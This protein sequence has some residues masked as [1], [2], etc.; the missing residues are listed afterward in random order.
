MKTL[1]GRS[2]SASGAGRGR[3]RSPRR[4]HR[5]GGVPARDGAPLVAHLGLRRPREPGAEAGR[6]HHR[7]HRRKARDH[8]APH[9]RQGPRA[10]EPL[11]AQGHEGRLRLRRQ[12][13]QDLPL[14]VPRLDLPYGRF[15][16]PHPAEGGL[17]KD[18]TARNRG[19][20][21][22]DAGHPRNLPRLRLRPP[23]RRPGVPRVLRRLALLHRQPRRPLARGRTGD[24]GRLPALSPQLQLEDVRGEPE[25][26][27]APDDRA[28][29]FRRHREAA[30]G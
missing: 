3:P 21:R 5:P 1:P 19:R 4:L 11:R 29:L 12:Y 2:A 28:R 7:R 24:R 15:P 13:R 25:R 23:R 16:P 6:L 9:R 20:G 18:Q 17:R 10:P 8:G 30:M 26:H 14:P 27:D 22:P